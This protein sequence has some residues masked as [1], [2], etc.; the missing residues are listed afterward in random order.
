[1]ATPFLIETPTNFVSIS[2]STDIPI[3]VPAV[4]GVG[5]PVTIGSLTLP[6]STR[7]NRVFIEGTIPLVFTTLAAVAA[8]GSIDVVLE[9]FRSNTSTTPIFRSRQTIVSGLT[10]LA[11]AVI[12]DVLPFQFVDDPAVSQCGG[13]ASYF[14]RVYVITSGIT[15][16]I[17]TLTVNSV[18]QGLFYNIIAEEKPAV[19]LTQLTCVFATPTT[20][21][22]PLI[23]PIIG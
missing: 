11:G 15:A 7:G 16:A 4:A 17:A 2:G 10:L 22:T 14:F 3:P 23:P 21:V 6:L 9:V 19:Q 8:T 13:S 18:A 20:T 12:Y 5:T 1:M